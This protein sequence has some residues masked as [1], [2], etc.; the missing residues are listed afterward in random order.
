V[1]QQIAEVEQL[2]SRWQGALG[3]NHQGY[4]NHIYRVIN[5]CA[6]QRELDASELRQVVITACFHDVAI[7]LD[8]TFDYLAP[9]HAHAQRYL[10]EQGCH[11]WGDVVGAMIEQHHKITPYR[12]NPLVETFR[13]AD[14]CDVTLGMCKFGI[15]AESLRALKGAFPN[16][17]FHPFL[18]RR[19][20]RELLT[21]PW[22][23]LP[24]MR[25]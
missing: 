16:A 22:R 23:P 14:W 25:W 9:S 8:D 24:M 17:G 7:W 18:L 15:P 3:R 1:L 2:I 13:R 21:R 4:K 11:A 10:E 5:L 19:S 12:H 6:L 20:V